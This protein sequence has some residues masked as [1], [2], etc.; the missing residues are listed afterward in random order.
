VLALIAAVGELIPM[1]GPILSAIPAI[2][3]A[4]TVSPE[5]ALAVAGIY[6]V[7]QLIEGSVLVPLVM[8]NAIGISPFL[9]LVSLLVGGAAGGLIGALV[10]VPIAAAIEI[11]LSRFQARDTP[12]VQDAAA[13]EP[14]E[15]AEAKDG[16]EAVI[17]AR[18]VGGDPRP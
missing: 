14:S 8:R 15:E 18:A 2:L 13:I 3:V 12:V 4:A 16:D 1:V 17:M 9:I 7:L 11:V 6:A 10:A 5:L